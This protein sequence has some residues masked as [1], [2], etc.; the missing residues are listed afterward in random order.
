MSFAG[1]LQFTALEMVSGLWIRTTIVYGSPNTDY[2]K[3][4]SVRKPNLTF[5]FRFDLYSAGEMFR[6]KS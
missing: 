4:R 5:R 3:R 1:T 2:C 6:V